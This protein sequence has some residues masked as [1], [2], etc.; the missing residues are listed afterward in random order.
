M[1]ITKENL[2]KLSIH[3]LEGLTEREACIL[4]RMDPTEFEENMRIDEKLR[5]F[6]ER[7]K[8]TFK[9]KHLLEIQSKR[10]PTNSQ[11]ILEKL[12]PDEF[13]PK[14]KSAPTTV[15][16]IGQIIKSIQN[17][18]QHSVL[19]PGNRG[20]FLGRDT[21]EEEGPIQIASVLK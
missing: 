4:C 16:I 5:N 12:R 9:Q 7:K 14:N 21:E 11:W 8:I 13:G 15:N 18:E 1:L 2:D 19:I 17:E 10:S 20:D 3:L 6:I